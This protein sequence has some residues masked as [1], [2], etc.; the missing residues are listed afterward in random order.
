[1]RENPDAWTM[2]L[3]LVNDSDAIAVHGSAVD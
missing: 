2:N 1:M 3:L